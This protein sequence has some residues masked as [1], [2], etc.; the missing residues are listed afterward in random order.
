[1]AKTFIE[2]RKGLSELLAVADG[3]EQREI[4]QHQKLPLL[5]EA[6]ALPA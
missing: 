2:N 3:D 6:A 1:M 4:L 5:P